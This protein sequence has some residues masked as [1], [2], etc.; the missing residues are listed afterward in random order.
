ME[1]PFVNALL[2]ST[3]LA[4]ACALLSVVV[5]LRRWAFIGEGIGHSGFGGAGTAWLLALILPVF[6]S[7]GA[8]YACVIL[9][10]LATALA[11]GLLSRSQRVNADAAIGIFLVA[12]L[13][14]GIL[15]E[16]IYRSRRGGAIPWGFETYLFG[17]FSD[18]GGQFTLAAIAVSAAV[19]LTVFLL[20]KEIIACCFDPLMAQTSGVAAGFVHYLLMFLIGLVIVIGVRVA[21]SVLITALLVL[22]GTT[23]LAVSRRMRSVVLIALVV[24]LVGTVGGLLVSRQWVEVP[25]GPAMVLI[26]FVQFIVA[27]TVGTARGS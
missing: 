21:G 9:F 23:A 27:Y 26:L 5:V 17:R 6:D 22:P 11:I 19:L 13:A 14:W 10:C 2:A 1:Q 3:A 4:S 18:F 12:S 7:P 25:M 24:A 15:A 8:T 16:R 20:R